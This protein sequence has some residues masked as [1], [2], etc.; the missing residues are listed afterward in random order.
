MRTII[1]SSQIIFKM[2]HFL[3]QGLLIDGDPRRM[4]FWEPVLTSLQNRLS[5]WKSRL[6]SFGGRLILL[7]SV[8]AL[9]FFKAPSSTI[10]T[11]ESLLIIFFWGGGEDRRK[12]SW[13][14]WKSICLHKEYEELGFDSCRSLI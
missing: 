10:Y 7:K 8:Y 9:F 4:S 3:Y 13:I 6:L 12:V 5:G 1:R 2:I 11:I 14:S